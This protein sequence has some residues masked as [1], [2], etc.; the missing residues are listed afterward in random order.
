M[1]NTIIAHQKPE[2]EW[3]SVLEI[4]TGCVSKG[5]PKTIIV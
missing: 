5:C 2:I 1:E 3:L 4:M